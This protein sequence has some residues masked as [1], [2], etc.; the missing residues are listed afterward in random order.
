MRPGGLSSCWLFMRKVIL[1]ILLLCFVMGCSTKYERHAWHFVKKAE[2]AARSDLRAARALLDSVRYPEVLQGS[3]VARYCLL[4]GML[5]DSLHTPLPFIDDLD[6]AWYYLDEHGTA[7]EQIRISRYYGQALMREGLA[8]PALN[9]FLKMR[10]ISLARKDY[11]SAAWACS[12]LGDI[13]HQVADYAL[14]KAY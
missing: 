8:D 4:G 9:V 14:S 7:G 12:Y 11:T 1:Y 2:R 13:S 5:S 6:R 10:D 3:M